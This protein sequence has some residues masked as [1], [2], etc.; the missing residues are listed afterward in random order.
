[1][2]VQ[3]AIDHLNANGEEIVTAT[4]KWQR[5]GFAYYA[6]V[7]GQMLTAAEVIEYAQNDHT[8]HLKP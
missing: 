5:R 4:D 1:M 3:D 6:K 2:T 7:A 8:L